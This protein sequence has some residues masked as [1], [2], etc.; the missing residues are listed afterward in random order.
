MT[1]NQILFGGIPSFPFPSTQ[2]DDESHPPPF[3][4][5]H[6]SKTNILSTSIAL[7]HVEKDRKRQPSPLIPPIFLFPCSL[8]LAAGN[9][10]AYLKNATKNITKNDPSHVFAV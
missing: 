3:P 1:K 6:V 7:I 8:V 9:C 5:F 2:D 4:Y 10:L